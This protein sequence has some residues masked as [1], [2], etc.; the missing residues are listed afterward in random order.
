MGHPEDEAVLLRRT[1][2]CEELA[3]RVIEPETIASALTRLIGNSLASS[4]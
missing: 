2:S 4:D 1:V 3:G